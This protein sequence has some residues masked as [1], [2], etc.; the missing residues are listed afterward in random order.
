MFV[1]LSDVIWTRDPASTRS[2]SCAGSNTKSNTKSGTRSGG[3]DQH[4]A[5]RPIR[6]QS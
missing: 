6:A 2:K 5:I 3:A 4:P 1:L